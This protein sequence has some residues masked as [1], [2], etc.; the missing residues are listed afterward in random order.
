MPKKS[1]VLLII[2]V[3]LLIVSAGCGTKPAAENP[4]D[5]EKPGEEQIAGVPLDPDTADTTKPEDFNH[6][7][8][9]LLEYFSES[10]A[11]RR[12]EAAASLFTAEMIEEIALYDYENPVIYL[13]EVF[14]TPD[15]ISLEITEETPDLIFAVIHRAQ[16]STGFVA[17]R[18]NG[19]WKLGF[20]T[21]LPAAYD[22]QYG[23]GSEEASPD[24]I[25]MILE[26]LTNGELTRDVQY[27]VAGLSKYTLRGD[28]EAFN[29]SQ[30]LVNTMYDYFMP[31][32]YTDVARG[33]GAGVTWNKLR[34]QIGAL[35]AS[36]Q[37]SLIYAE[38]VDSVSFQEEISRVNQYANEVYQS[39]A[40][41]KGI[42]EANI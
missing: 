24:A 41:L 22:D 8:I 29:Q 11:N 1:Y 12:Y 31:V 19:L 14:S 16:G 10:L 13:Q 3:I 6:S 37:A 42:L 33:Y 30:S 40:E 25:L 4:Q 9:A 34:E 2:I 39:A 21:L 38:A 35:N 20:E 7:G 36:M 26:P 23:Y 18:E 5:E 32:F 27:F 28:Q 17:Y 15:N